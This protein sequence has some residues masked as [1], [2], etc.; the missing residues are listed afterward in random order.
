MLKIKR[1]T[2][3]NNVNDTSVGDEIEDNIPDDGDFNVSR[4]ANFRCRY[5]FN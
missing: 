2:T 3:L 4:I 1:R 5:L